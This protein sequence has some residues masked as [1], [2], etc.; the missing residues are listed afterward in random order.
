MHEENIT[1]ISQIKDRPHGNFQNLTEWKVNLILNPINNGIFFLKN[2]FT[3][4]NILCVISKLVYTL[5]TFIFY[6]NLKFLFFSN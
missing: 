5:N 6:K 3:I 1:E 2:H 4:T